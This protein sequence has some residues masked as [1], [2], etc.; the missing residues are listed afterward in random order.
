[1]TEIT[2][3]P[4]LDYQRLTSI[5][6]SERELFRSAAPFP[7]IVI[8]NFITKDLVGQLLAEIPENAQ[9]KPR[10]DLGD[11]LV[12]GN[13]AQ[14]KKDFLSMEMLAGRATRQLYWELNCADFML[15][16][17][18]LT[19]VDYLLPDPYLFGGGIHETRSGGYLVL[20][21]DFNK[22]KEL[23]LDRR[24]NIIIYLNE[25]WQDSYG[26]FLQ[27]WHRDQSACVKAVRPLAGRAV[28][29]ATEADTWHG[30]PEPLA[31]PE[32][33]TR[34]SIAL[35]YYSRSRNGVEVPAKKTVWLEHSTSV[36]FSKVEVV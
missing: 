13:P 23:G 24:L 36:D 3:S 18:Q 12:S 1:M 9:H 11:M 10:K 4:L 6:S 29:F 17:Q 15:F 26:G 2:W 27:L 33:V 22:Q 5:A 34:K 30:H 19:G 31:T 20:H 28:I 16:L 25:E 35:Y 32:G 8:D 14:F 7:H 21:A